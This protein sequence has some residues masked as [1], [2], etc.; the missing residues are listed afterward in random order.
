MVPYLWLENNTTGKKGTVVRPAIF[1]AGSNYNQ[2]KLWPEKK[3]SCLADG[4][5]SDLAGTKY[6]HQLWYYDRKKLLPEKRYSCLAGYFFRRV[7]IT[8]RKIMTG[9]KRYSRL[10]DGWNKSQITICRVKIHYDRK[11]GTVIW[12]SVGAQNT[13]HNTHRHI[14]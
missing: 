1:S 7:Q 6:K 12:S 11:K 3:Y 13:K 9:K 8:T 2:K 14:P 4:G 5:S 10:A